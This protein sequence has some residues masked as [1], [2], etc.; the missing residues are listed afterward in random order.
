MLFQKPLSNDLQIKRFNNMLNKKVVIEK[1]MREAFGLQNI[2][3]SKL[4]TQKV[5]ERLSQLNSA[6]RKEIEAIVGEKMVEYGV[7]PKN[8]LL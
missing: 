8:E 6:E 5:N 4:L 7:T 1:I 2:K 3:D